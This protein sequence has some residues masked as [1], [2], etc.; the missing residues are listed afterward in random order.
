MS[1]P[2]HV[3]RLLAIGLTAVLAVAGIWAGV[4]TASKQQISAWPTTW[5][6]MGSDPAEAGCLDHRNVIEA[7]YA[8]D[9]TYLWT[10]RLALAD[11]DGD[12]D[13]DLI[14]APWAPQRADIYRNDGTGHFQLTGVVDD[15]GF[16]DITAAQMDHAG[17]MDM[18]FVRAQGVTGG[19]GS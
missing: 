19:L 9:S 18:R 15:E 2:K 17:G 13:I 5:T 12:G 6:S 8:L 14:R 7:F 3:S 11:V 10:S 4:R 1:R 16:D